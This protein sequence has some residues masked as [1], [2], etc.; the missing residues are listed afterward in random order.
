ME[1]D[2][3]RVDI[4]ATEINSPATGL[5]LLLVKTAVLDDIGWHDSRAL[6][7][8]DGT[9]RR[10]VLALKLRVVCDLEKRPHRNVALLGVFFDITGLHGRLQRTVLTYYTIWYNDVRIVLSEIQ[11]YATAPTMEG[12]VLWITLLEHANL[13]YNMSSSQKR[14]VDGPRRE[15]FFHTYKE[16]RQSEPPFTTALVV[17]KNTAT[18]VFLSPT[19]HTLDK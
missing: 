19:A 5:L 4:S 3:R 17:R 13:W 10:G 8:G 11:P 14:Q 7:V 2:K 18:G 12:G 1:H 6:H 15:T 16:S 9:L